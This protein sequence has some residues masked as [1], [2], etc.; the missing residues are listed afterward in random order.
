MSN[1][2]RRSVKTAVLR[3]LSSQY[4]SF[5]DMLEQASALSKDF[6]L[7]VS[8]ILV[9]LLEKKKEPAQEVGSNSN[10]SKNLTDVAIADPEHKQQPGE[11]DETD[12]DDDYELKGQQA[13]PW[14]KKLFKKIALHCHPDKVGNS[15]HRKILLYMKARQA[16]DDLNEPMMISIGVEFDETPDIPLEETKQSL[17]THS[18]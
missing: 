3:T 16:L 9:L 14:I 18:A 6:E 8:D 12:V 4:T 5:Y 10:D 1:V 2:K 15:D 7:E 13:H 17:K 11:Q